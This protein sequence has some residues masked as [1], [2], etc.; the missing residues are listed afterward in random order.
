MALITRITRLFKADINAIIDSIEEPVSLLKQSVREMEDSILEDERHLASVVEQYNNL[1]KTLAELSGLL[2]HDEEEL[3]LCFEDNN[4][5]LA[6]AIVKRRLERMQYRNIQKERYSALG[7]SIDE[8]T[9][10]LIANRLSLESMRYKA[11]ILIDKSDDAAG[12]RSFKVTTDIH[13]TQEDVDVAMLRE[14]KKRSQ[15]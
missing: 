4:E 8:L 6:R 2:E 12:S 3:D 15:S 11:E 10:K 9:K 1:E 5:E 14:K 7:K 13:I